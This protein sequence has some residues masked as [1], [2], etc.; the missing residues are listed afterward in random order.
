MKKKYNLTRI[1]KSELFTILVILACFVLTFSILSDK[2]F[3]FGNLLN[4]ARQ[5]SV[6]F[7]TALGMTLLLVTAGVDISVGAIM[8]IAGVFSSAALVDFGL[9][10]VLSIFIGI[11]L[12]ALCGFFNGFIVIKTGIAPIIVTLATTS[13]F[14]SFPYLYT[15][16]EPIFGLSDEFKAIG[17]GYIGAIPIPVALM[18]MLGIF[19]WVLLSKTKFGLRLYAIGSSEKGAEL[20]GISVKTYKLITYVITGALA[21]LSG[22]ILT[23]RLGSGVSSAGKDFAFDVLTGTLIG[24]VSLNGGK[25]SVLGALIGCLIMGVMGNGLNLLNVSTYYQMLFKGVMLL[26]AVSIDTYAKAAKNKT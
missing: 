9:N 13:I 7:I 16:A 12:G 25:G 23:A 11:A 18:T 21:G 22:V 24:G 6:L 1:F 8:C 17:Q 15:N 5:V 2:F 3:T 4:I 19:F 26:A 14:Q 20:T 10:P